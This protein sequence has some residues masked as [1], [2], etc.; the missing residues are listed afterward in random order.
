[1]SV[2][3]VFDRNSSSPLPQEEQ[4]EGQADAAAHEQL[5]TALIAGTVKGGRTPVDANTFEQS[6]AA[7][8]VVCLWPRRYPVTKGQIQ[9]SRVYYLVGG[10]AA[11]GVKK[12]PTA[13]HTLHSVAGLGRRVQLGPCTALVLES[14]CNDVNLEDVTISGVFTWLLR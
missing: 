13:V 12:H 3:A 4:S 1:M 14:T 9:T 7:W 11:T 2:T 10:E 6:T 8:A 5:Q